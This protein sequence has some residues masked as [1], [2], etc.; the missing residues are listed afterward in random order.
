MYDP[1][2]ARVGL[3]EPGRERLWGDAS[4]SALPPFLRRLTPG[5]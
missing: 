2:L 3:L 1:P 5:V 4:L